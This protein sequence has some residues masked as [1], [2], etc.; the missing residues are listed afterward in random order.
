[1][2]VTRN[3]EDEPTLYESVP[4]IIPINSTLPTRNT[5]VDGLVDSTID[6]KTARMKF[7]LGDGLP[8]DETGVAHLFTQRTYSGP[9]R[10]YLSKGTDN[11]DE[12]LVEK[13]LRLQCEVNSLKVLNLKNLSKKQ[14]V[15]DNYKKELTEDDYKKLEETIDQLDMTAKTMALDEECAPLVHENEEIMKESTLS[16]SQTVL[17]I[18][19][20]K[21]I[22]SELTDEKEESEMLKKLKENCCEITSNLE[23][24]QLSKLNSLW[25]RLTDLSKIVGRNKNLEAQYPNHSLS[26]ILS[27][28]HNQLRMVDVNVVVSVESQLRSIISLYENKEQKEITED[29]TTA[30][31][32]KKVNCLLK[33]F[34]EWKEKVPIVDSILKRLETIKTINEKGA[35]HEFMIS[36]LKAQ[37]QLTKKNNEE[38][39]KQLERMEKKTDELMEVLRSAS[40]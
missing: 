13:I 7:V 17:S 30:T 18:E 16:N 36:R 19:N 12:N 28:I 34:E 11:E 39:T 29:Q 20:L 4:D 32:N 5:N 35:E 22:L 8:I 10:I 6:M 23:N 33:H 25:E 9:E 2:N 21:R 24:E 27:I 1:M 14:I 40:N 31:T 3:L 15:E 38:L 37:Q 26:D